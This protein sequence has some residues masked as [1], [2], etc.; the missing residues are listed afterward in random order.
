MHPHLWQTSKSLG[1]SLLYG[2]VTLLPLCWAGEDVAVSTDVSN[3]PQQ[4]QTE[5]TSSAQQQDQSRAAAALFEIAATPSVTVSEPGGGAS[6]VA[7]SI[8]SSRAGGHGCIAAEEQSTNT[9]QSFLALPTRLR[10]AKQQH[11]GDASGNEDNS[12]SAEARS[13]ENSVPSQELTATGEMPQV[14]TTV[15]T[16]S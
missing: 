9:V 3:Q 15:G 7:P 10:I 14:L 4:Q 2:W 13:L 6:S 16:L 8:E 5:V 11:Q 12:V 1:G